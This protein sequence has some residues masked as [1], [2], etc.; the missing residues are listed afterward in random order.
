MPESKSSIWF[1][2]IGT[3]G[4]AAIVL[5]VLWNVSAQYPQLFPAVSTFFGGNSFFVALLLLL[6]SLTRYLRVRQPSVPMAAFMMAMEYL[7]M[8]IA[9]VIWYL[10]APSPFQIPLWTCLGM[11]TI[12]LGGMIYV[13]IP[14]LRKLQT[15]A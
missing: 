4:Y 3:S 6:D 11:L 9:I 7:T 8:T 5:F 1:K 12:L 15:R 14:L 2:I 13:E 10:F